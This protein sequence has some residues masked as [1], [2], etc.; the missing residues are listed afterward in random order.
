MTH[1]EELAR[2]WSAV[3]MSNYGTPPVALDSGSGGG[4]ESSSAPPH[5]ATGA[6]TSSATRTIERGRR[7][8]R[9]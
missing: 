9:V 1:T 3:M 2:R 5:A 7:T 8:R 6:A 4:A